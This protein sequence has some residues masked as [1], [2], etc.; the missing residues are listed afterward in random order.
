MVKAIKRLGV[1]SIRGKLYKCATRLSC[2]SVLQGSVVQVC[3]KAQLY[4][5]ATRLSCTSV[6]QGSV[7]QVCYKAQ[8]YKCATRLSCTSVL[9]ATVLEMIRGS[10]W[11]LWFPNDSLTRDSHHSTPTTNAP[12]LVQL[13]QF[14][15]FNLANCHVLSHLHI[16][17]DSLDLLNL[18]DGGSGGASVKAS[19]TAS[20]IRSPSPSG[21]SVFKVRKYD[22]SYLSLGFTKTIINNQELP[23]CVICL[24]VLTS[25]S[26]KP[27]KTKNT[28]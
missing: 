15:V 27:K 2:T 6:L 18:F 8:L 24:A 23:Q 7:V 1:G 13:V 10:A 4:K 26:M 3:Y 22:N 19:D 25:D 17:I 12:R 28:P 20:V 21:P 11:L 16:F 5:C 9:Q 14:H